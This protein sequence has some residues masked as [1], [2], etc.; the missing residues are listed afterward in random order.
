[1]ISP[2]LGFENSVLTF[3]LPVPGSTLTVDEWGNAISIGTPLVVTAVLKTASLF[4]SLKTQKDPG[5]DET[6]LL[7]EGWCVTPML[8]PFAILPLNWA[9]CVWCGDVGKFYLNDPI[10]APYGRTTMDNEGSIGAIQ[11]LNGGTAITGWF[12]SKKGV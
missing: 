7:L 6:A 11:E 12:Q 8:L 4:K 9:D 3:N 2:L 5:I 10:N 1:M